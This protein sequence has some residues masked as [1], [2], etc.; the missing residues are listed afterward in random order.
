MSGFLTF[1]CIVGLA[2]IIYA[3][4]KGFWDKLNR[5]E[6]QNDQLIRDN[7]RLRGKTG[8]LRNQL[9]IDNEKSGKR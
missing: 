4:L 9:G 8:S 7:A 5:L 3:L 2:T 6:E 1:V